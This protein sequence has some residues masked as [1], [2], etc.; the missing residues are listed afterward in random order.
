MSSFQLNHLAEKIR[1]SS[2]SCGQPGC[3]DEPCLCA[4]CAQ[5]LGVA[6]DDPTHDPDCEGC[7][8]CHVPIILFRGHG[9][10]MKQAAFHATCFRKL[11]DP[12]P[13]TPDGP[14][15]RLFLR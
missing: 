13:N 2:G 1:W 6:E 7:D 10:R 14:A 12:A 8:R 5:P 11:T 15:A 3:T 4:L 9:K